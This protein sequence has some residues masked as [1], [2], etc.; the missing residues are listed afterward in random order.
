MKRQASGKIWR[1]A[2]EWRRIM[3]RYEKSGLTIEAFCRRE[4]VPK[5]SFW[6]WRRR[7]R[8]EQVPAKKSFVEIVPQK[9]EPEAP[10]R[11]EI[12]FPNGAV[13]RVC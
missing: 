7:L 10:L 5:N 12:Q 11:V 1:T 13:L 9:A 3:K 2:D 8:K 4:G 6:N